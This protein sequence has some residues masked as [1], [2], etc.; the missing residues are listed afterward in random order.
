MPNNTA[1]DLHIG[2]EEL[3]L[4]QRYTV[5]SIA[6][7]LLSGLWFVIGS[8]LFFSPQTTHTGTWL[9]LIGSIQMLFR[10]VIRLTRQ[11][12]LGRIGSVVPETAQDF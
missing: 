9:F 2:H 7:D 6:N 5:L 10:P 11:I 8:I 4:R 3:Q 1:L 12:H